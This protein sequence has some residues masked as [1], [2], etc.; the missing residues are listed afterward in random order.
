MSALGLP[1]EYRYR[2]Q[3]PAVGDRLASRTQPSDVDCG[4]PTLAYAGA[5]DARSAAPSTRGGAMRFLIDLSMVCEVRYDL[6]WNRP[7]GIGAPNS[8][9]RLAC[10]VRTASGCITGS[11]TLRHAAATAGSATSIS[12]ERIGTSGAAPGLAA[13]NDTMVSGSECAI[14]ASASRIL[15]STSPPRSAACVSP[16][17]VMSGLP[18][19]RPPPWRREVMSA[20]RRPE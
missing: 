19:I 10:P 11:C 16:D 13:P 1:K 6:A 5:A 9:H 8:T 3:G 14:S 20:A 12:T 2:S 17:A 18:R 15:L 4:A 7:S